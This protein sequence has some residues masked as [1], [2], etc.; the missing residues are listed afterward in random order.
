MDFLTQSKKY[1]PELSTVKTDLTKLAKDV[2]SS[3]ENQYH[4]T[5]LKGGYRVCWK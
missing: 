1:E 2:V 3:I 5:S 4:K